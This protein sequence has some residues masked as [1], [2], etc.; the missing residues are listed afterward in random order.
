MNHA[1]DLKNYRGPLY[2]GPNPRRG[3]ALVS[4]LR[5]G[6]CVRCGVCGRVRA[7]DPVAAGRADHRLNRNVRA[8]V[9][10]SSLWA[11]GAGR[12]AGGAPVWCEECGDGFDGK[13][14]LL[15][16]LALLTKS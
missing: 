12:L 14:V 9:H 10:G 13:L 6:R 3:S 15:D 8:G 2:S 16:T 7:G 5:G 11:T 4:V 1:D